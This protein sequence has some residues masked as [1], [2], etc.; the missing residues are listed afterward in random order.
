MSKNMNIFSK[1]KHGSPNVKLF[2]TFLHILSQ[3]IF[4]FSQNSMKESL[5][6]TAFKFFCCFY[7]IQIIKINIAFIV[8][9]KSIL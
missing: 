1:K 2:S 6:M 4:I 8:M 7:A 3:Q 9:K 5:F